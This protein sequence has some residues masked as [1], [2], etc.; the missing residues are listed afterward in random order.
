MMLERRGLTLLTMKVSFDGGRGKTYSSSARQEGQRDLQWLN[1]VHWRRQRY[2]F[3]SLTISS[4]PSPTHPSDMAARL[5]SLSQFSGGIDDH[6][7]SSFFNTVDPTWDPS[8]ESGKASIP[9]AFR[10]TDLADINSFLIQ[11]GADV[12][13]T[14][15]GPKK[16]VGN[17]SSSGASSSSNSQPALSPY[18]SDYSTASPPDSGSE[19]GLGDINFDLSGLTSIQGFDES[20]LAGVNWNGENGNQE[21]FNFNQQNYQ[22][23]PIAQLPA[24]GGQQQQQQFS[25][26]NFMN[27]SYQQQG[28]SSSFGGN[29]QSTTS[30][31]SL[32]NSRGS[33]LVPQLAGYEG[34]NHN[35]RKVDAL[36]R[37]APVAVSNARDEEMEEL[38]DRKT[39]Y[40]SREVSPAASESSTS[41]RTSTSSKLS[42]GG[43]YPKVS[44]HGDL[45]RKLPSP[46]SGGSGGQSISSILASY[47]SRNN[48]KT[49][50]DRSFRAR[51]EDT[52]S[53]E[54]ASNRSRSGS[55][56]LESPSTPA[57]TTTS[58]IYPSLK[59]DEM[60][61]EQ[62]HDN[63]RN[64]GLSQSN[65][66][67]SDYETR[68]KHVEFIRRLL[69]AINFPRQQ[70][71]ESNSGSDSDSDSSEER[72][73]PP[74]NPSLS[75][76][77]PSLPS[78]DQL[79]LTKSR[80]NSKVSKE[81]DGLT[82]H[83]LPPLRMREESGDLSRGRA[84]GVDV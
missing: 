63:L 53:D 6:A 14:G 78:I 80:R 36:Q 62:V 75:E 40:R 65:S 21:E 27:N 13:R 66:K 37:A 33:A 48:F 12:A 70:Q 31:D 1:F 34:L 74:M 9:D 56:G 2:R 26:S 77:S 50:N 60:E 29:G 11:L 19:H 57:T 25:G 67:L 47:P 79:L 18:S 20:L 69:Y 41:T 68:K 8:V 51:S 49:S 83:S 38:D 24:R 71:S 59:S 3:C 35:Y 7:V 54:T 84:G 16:E 39:S 76:K 43:L 45:S 58:R 42:S 44:S 82:G 23:R 5:N 32:R 72:D 15:S 10:T 61:V 52:Q 17:S 55:Y 73:L 28:G 22:S 4:F 64:L 46:S 30:F 81:R